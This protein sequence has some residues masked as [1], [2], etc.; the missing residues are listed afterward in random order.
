LEKCKLALVEAR[1]QY[2]SDQ[3]QNESSPKLLDEDSCLGLWR[4]L[5]A[6]TDNLIH[7]SLGMELLTVLGSSGIIWRVIKDKVVQAILFSRLSISTPG[8]SNILF[9]DFL[10]EDQ[11]ASQ[12]KKETHASCAALLIAC[13]GGAGR[14]ILNMNRRKQ[15]GIY[16]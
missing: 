1:K 14:T 10:V 15:D 4:V 11:S 6:N 2:D 3:G 5:F 12:I 9:V 13:Q 8:K 7:D 16:S